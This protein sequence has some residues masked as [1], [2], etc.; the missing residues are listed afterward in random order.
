MTA[1]YEQVWRML[2]LEEVLPVFP[3]VDAALQTP[4]MPAACGNPDGE[5]AGVG[6][7]TPW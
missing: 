3:T 1:H 5:D 4:D 7:P 6:V 2:G